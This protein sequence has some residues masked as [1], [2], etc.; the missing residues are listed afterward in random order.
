MMVELRK[1]IEA[2]ID[3]ILEIMAEGHNESAF[4]GT[5]DEWTARH[6]LM[7]FMQ[8][9]HSTLMLAVDGNKILGGVMMAASYEWCLEPIA[10]VVKFWVR[11]SAR[12]TR[13]SRHLM[14]YIDE[15]ARSWGCSSVYATATAEL[16][17]TEQRL[18]ENL[19]A[20]HGFADC[21]ATLKKGLYNG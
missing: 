14:Q 8:L 19:F 1:A 21:G 16:D 11:A 12:R 20:K 4:V 5:F 15:F 2:D 18:F 10:Y 6:Y 3:A 7:G 13:A 9:E 17:K